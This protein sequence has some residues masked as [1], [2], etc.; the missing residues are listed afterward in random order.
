LR[1]GRRRGGREAGAREFA[2]CR[3]ARPPARGYTIRDEGAGAR[4]VVSVAW[5]EGLFVSRRPHCSAMRIYAR[6][7]NRVLSVV[8]VVL[9]AVCTG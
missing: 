4:C 7:A 1:G 9:C 5:R 3:D 2:H 6:D 8:R